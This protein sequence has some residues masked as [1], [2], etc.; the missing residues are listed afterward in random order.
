MVFVIDPI[1]KAEE[2]KLKYLENK[3][4]AQIKYL[5]GKKR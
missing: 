4:I 3:F 2:V 1:I 5:E